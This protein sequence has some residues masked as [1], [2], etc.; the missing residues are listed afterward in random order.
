ME[1]MTTNISDN[2]PV[3]KPR[4]LRNIIIAIIGSVVL[5]CVCLFIVIVTNSNKAKQVT[6]ISSP[7]IGP[8]A[9]EAPPTETATSIYTS[10]P[11]LTPTITDTPTI[12][13]TPTITSTPTKTP[14]PSKTPTATANPFLYEGRGDQVVDI[15]KPDP[16]G[17]GIMKISYSGGGN[18]VVENY[19]DQGNQIELLVNVIGSYKGTVPLDF[20]E[21][22]ST[23]RLQIT[24]SGNWTIE[25]LPMTEV[26]QETI[27]GQIAGV[28]D[29]VVY[30]N[31]TNPDLLKVDASS[32]RDNFVVWSY[33]S[34]RN[35]LVNQIAPYTGTV[36]L[37]NDTT[38]LVIQ[39][40]GK[41]SL[42]VTTR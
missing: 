38:I 41:W 1:I 27:P 12:T 35:L 2:N 14:L 37:P 29:D 33:G 40:T 25:I 20:L 5:V 26:R 8:S 34:N 7:T 15:T 19:D 42:A 32:A 24:S 23:T 16:S 6:S 18:F 30:L 36:I 11:S 28:G 13:P 10:T 4:F 22:E 39:A 21:N 9:T 3:R 31:G 17:P